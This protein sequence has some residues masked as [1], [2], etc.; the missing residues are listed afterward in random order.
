MKD[1]LY[2]LSFSEAIFYLR[3][4]AGYT[5]RELA[6]ALGVNFTYISKIENDKLTIMPSEKLIKKMA[7]LLG[8]NSEYLC[9]LAGK[10]DFYGLQNAAQDDPFVIGRLL[11]WIAKGKFTEHEKRLLRDLLVSLEGKS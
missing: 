7:E 9:T 2:G 6:D 1:R 8:G 10:F 3:T 4:E 5:Q 11:R